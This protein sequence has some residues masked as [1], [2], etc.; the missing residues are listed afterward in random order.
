MAKVINITDKLSLDKPKIVL[1][2]KTYEVNDSMETVLKFQ[3]LAQNSTTDNMEAAIKLSLGDKA[4]KELNIK[5]MSIQNFRVLTI[6]I[7]AAMQNIEYEEAEA[8]FQKLQQ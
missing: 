6:A 1:G 8:R 7:L 2:E 4:A 3:E 5:K